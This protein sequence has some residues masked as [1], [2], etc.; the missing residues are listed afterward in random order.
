LLLRLAGYAEKTADIALEPQT[1]QDVSLK[2]QPASANA[3]R[4]DSLSASADSSADHRPRF[5]IVPYVAIGAGAASLLGA[6]GFELA[7]RSADSAA[8]D[9]PQ[10]EFQGHYDTMQGRQTAAR[11]L[12]GVGGALLATGGVMLVVDMQRKPSSAQRDRRN[13]QGRLPQVALGCDGDRCSLVA[14]GSFQ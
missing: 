4:R 13:R 7:R 6:L 3:S 2:L 10:T 1:P 9:A 14:K 11:V 5:G 12:A 8:E